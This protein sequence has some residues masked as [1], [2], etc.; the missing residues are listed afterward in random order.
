MVQS[1]SHDG[2]SASNLAAST[3][4]QHASRDF[5]RLEQGKIRENWVLVD[6]IDMYRQIDVD[7]FARLREFNKARNLGAIAWG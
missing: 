2:G 5:W 6:L 1:L 7:V 4:V 3:T